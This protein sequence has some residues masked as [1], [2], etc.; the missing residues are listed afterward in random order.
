MDYRLA[1]FLE[2]FNG[3]KLSN[4]DIEVCT[5]LDDELVRHPDT[6]LHALASASVR[7]YLSGRREWWRNAENVE[8]LSR[9]RGL[10]WTYLGQPD[11]PV[12][13]RHL[14]RQPLVF[15]YQGQPVWKQTATL[16]VV[17]SRIPS[18]DTCFWLQREFARFLRRQPIAVVSGGARGVDQWAHRLALS[19]ERPTIC[20]LPSGLLNP[21]PARMDDLWEE[22]LLQDGC[23]LSTF[24]LHE[25]MRKSFFQVR[26]RWIA[27]L[28]AVTFIVEANRKSGTHLTASLARDEGRDVCALPM[29][30]NATQGLANLDLLANGAGLI[31]DAEDLEVFCQRN[32]NFNSKIDEESAPRTEKTVH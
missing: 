15:S 25:P 13:W 22:I 7:H 14:S 6:L 2:T 9:Q 4:D 8:R 16:S 29:H 20:I 12:L 17:G 26:N 24:P 10:R 21:Y 27:G 31:R 11:Y 30:P 5:G 23:V 18:Q 3:L 1:L 28:S 19:A 32:L